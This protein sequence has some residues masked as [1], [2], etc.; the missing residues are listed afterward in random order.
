MYPE[1]RKN[2]PCPNCGYVRLTCQIPYCDQEGAYEAWF[3]NGILLQRLVC[4]E[5]HVKESVG[6]KKNGQKAIDS[7]KVET[8]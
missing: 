7:A 6:Y 5:L 8:Y 2:E 4:C 1:E 3:K